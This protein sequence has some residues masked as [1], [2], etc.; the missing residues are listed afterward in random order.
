MG[1]FLHNTLYGQNQSIRG[2][3]EKLSYEIFANQSTKVQFCC[4]NDRHSNNFSFCITFEIYIEKLIELSVSEV[5]SFAKKK[6]LKI[7]CQI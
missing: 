7:F 2:E 4:Q 1:S 6:N 3:W 5:I